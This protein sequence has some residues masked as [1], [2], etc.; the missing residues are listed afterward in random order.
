[1]TPLVI[2]IAW[3]YLTFG[4]ILL[5]YFCYD[6]G[7]EYESTLGI[8]FIVTALLIFWLPVMIMAIISNYFDGLKRKRKER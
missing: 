8:I 5:I 7:F 2:D 6:Q 1:M 4:M 3:Y